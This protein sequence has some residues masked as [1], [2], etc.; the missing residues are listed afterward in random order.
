M[1]TTFIPTLLVLTALV[2]LS[3]CGGKELETQNAQ[4]KAQLD[5]L[6]TEVANL[7]QENSRLLE[8]TGDQ[9]QVGFEVQIGAFENFNLDAYADELV[10]FREVE[11]DG[12]KKYVL[13]RFRTFEDAEA[14]LADLK[15]FG[16][17]DAFIAGIVDG[18]RTSV[19]EAKAAA[20]DYYGDF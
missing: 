3:T 18:R 10:R 1:R 13:G 14:F 12:L 2:I 17:Y 4:L 11:S 19:D 16:M 9:L 20:R 6:Q 5:T 7:R 8:T 15:S